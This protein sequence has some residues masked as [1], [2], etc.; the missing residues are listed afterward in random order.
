MAGTAA[1]P[2]EGR[3]D[4]LVATMRVVVQCAPAATTGVAIPAW[5]WVRTVEPAPPVTLAL[6]A[7]AVAGSAAVSWGNQPAAP[8][9]TT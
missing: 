6:Q 5:R 9:A 8:T 1:R 4:A 7:T 3:T 2:K